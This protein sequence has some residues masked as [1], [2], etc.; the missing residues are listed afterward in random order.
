[1]IETYKKRT[2]KKSKLPIIEF[3]RMRGHIM[4]IGTF[5]VYLTK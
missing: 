3:P 4:Q 2:K 5:T 1:M